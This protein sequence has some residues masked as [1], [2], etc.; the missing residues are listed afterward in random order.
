V[1]YALFLPPGPIELGCSTC[2]QLDVLL[3]DATGTL[4]R[5]LRAPA[6]YLFTDFMCGQFNGVCKDSS[7]VFRI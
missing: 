4:G 7:E 3:Y 1:T 5:F 2:H 6:E